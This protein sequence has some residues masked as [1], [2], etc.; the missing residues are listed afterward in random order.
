M[1]FSEYAT[2]EKIEYAKQL[3]KNATLAELRVFSFLKGRTPTWGFQVPVGGYIA[4]FCCPRLR[5]VLE[6][7]GSSHKHRKKS[8]AKRDKHLLAF[9]WRTIRMTNYQALHYSKK[10]FIEELLLQILG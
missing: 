1:H 5:I 10:K 6:I 7:D 3:R 4:D 9:G 8:D 2:P